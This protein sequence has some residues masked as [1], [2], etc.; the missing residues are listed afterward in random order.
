[1]VRREGTLKTAPQQDRAIAG[2]DRILRATERLLRKRH[3]E[4]IGIAQILKESGVS[5]SSF[6][7]RFHSKEDVL[8]V[9][10][11]KYSAGQR[12]DAVARFDPARL[13]GLDL[14]ARI[15]LLTREAVRTYR[16]RRGLLRTVALLARSR[17]QAVSKG[18]LS[19]RAEQYEAAAALLLECRKE[20]RH[21]EPVRA[22]PAGILMVLAT[23]RDKIL[24]AEAPHPASVRLSDDELAAE[25]ARALFAYLST[26]PRF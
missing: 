17:P 8:P 23:C 19:E 9:L 4:D 5:A 1:M 14:G 22:V 24:F 3:F 18:A 10:Y 6:Y 26:T 15:Q 2:L 13:R 16:E 21:P 12:K 25:L 7:S 11:A 20:I